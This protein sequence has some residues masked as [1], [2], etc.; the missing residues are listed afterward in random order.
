MKTVQLI[1]TGALFLLLGAVAPAYAQEEAKGSKQE[2]AK[3]AKQEEKATPAKQEEKATPA[4]QEEKAAPAKQQEKAQPAKQEE[5]A[6]PAKQEEKAQPAKQEAKAAPAKQEEKAEPAKQEENAKA[7]PQEHGQPQRT[8]QAEAKQR[9]EPALRLSV[10]GSARIPDDRFRASFGTDHRFS[11]GS[12]TLEGGFSRF[13]YGGFS[14]GFV[15]PWPDGWYYTDQVY[16]DYLDGEYFLFN[17][18]YPG[19]RIGISVVL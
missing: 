15:Q 13:Q 6:T 5:K 18:Y 4:K 8:Q 2:E 17:P 3:P 9:S 11:I 7:A 19:V 14:F 16:V 10:N 12:P 1:S